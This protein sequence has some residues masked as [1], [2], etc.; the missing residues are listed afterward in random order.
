MAAFVFS[1]LPT[2]WFYKEGCQKI[3]VLGVAV[4]GILYEVNNKFL[5]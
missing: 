4:L 1:G 5:M 3:S 2:V